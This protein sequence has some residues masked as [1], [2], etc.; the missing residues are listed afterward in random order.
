MRSLRVNRYYAL[1]HLLTLLV[2]LGMKKY[3]T[4]QKEVELF[5]QR[6]GTP[7]SED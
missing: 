7:E 3:W 1:T 5:H 2:S 4:Y 6:M